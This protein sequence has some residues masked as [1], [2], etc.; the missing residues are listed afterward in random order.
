M[1]KTMPTSNYS[2]KNISL[3]GA[4]F[5][6]APMK[7]S[8]RAHYSMRVDFN[9]GWLKAIVWFLY[10]VSV[11]PLWFCSKLMVDT[12]SQSTAKENESILA[13]RWELHDW[14]SHRWFMWSPKLPLPPPSRRHFHIARHLAA[15]TTDR[16]LNRNPNRRVER[17]LSFF[18]ALFFC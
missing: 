10:S 6:I 17:K 5:S 1:T 15:R 3:F 12:A 8:M 4:F 16:P 14:Q 11:D 13:E 18:V 9:E 7:M 2:F